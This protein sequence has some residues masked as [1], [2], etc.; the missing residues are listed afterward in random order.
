MLEEFF[1]P[2]S[3]A[4]LGAST[5]EQKLGH[6]VLKNVIQYG[7]K[8]KV[9]PINPRAESVLGLPAFRDVL[10]V[11]EP[12]DLAIM[13]VPPEA[14][15]GA[16]R[17]C[18]EKGV[19]G[20]I[21]ITAGFREIGPEG[22][23]REKELVD[24]V[25]RSGM[26]LLGPNVLGLIDTHSRLN[27]SFAARMPMEG[28]ISFL[29]QSGALCTAILDWAAKE[30]L[31]FLK[32]VS[33]GNKADLNEGDFLEALHEDPLTKVIIAYLEGIVDGRQ[34][35]EVASE[36]TKQKPVIVVKSGTTSA[37]MRAVSSHTGT[38]AGSE[39]AYDAAF[40]QS[41]VIRA[42]SIE[43]LFD[44]SMAFSYQPIPRGRNLAIVTNAGGPGILATDAAEKQGDAL[45]LA[46]FS[47]PTIEYLRRHLP[48]TANVYN[49]VDLIGD[50]RADRYAIALN[51]L[52][53]EPNVNAVLV[54][55][56]PQAVTEVDETA[57]VV[58]EAA[59]NSDKT[60]LA[61]FMGGVDVESGVRI[62]SEGRVPNYEFPE[63]A[64]EALAAMS[65]Q[66]VW[67][68]KKPDY[69]V[70]FQVDKETVRHVLAAAKEDG[71]LT[72]GDLETRQVLSAYGLPVT[73]SRVAKTPEEAA[74]YADEIGYPVV[75]KIVSPDI[76]HKS[77]VGGVRVGVY[78]PEAVKEAF[79]EIVHRVYSFMPDAEIWGIDVQEMVKPGRE[80]IIGVSNDPQFGHLIMFGLG[81]IYVEVMR[82][83]T[84]RVAPLT[85]EEARA[86]TR[87]I[88][89]YPLLM[90]VRGQPPADMKTLVDCLLRISQLVQ[91]FPQINELDINPLVLYS[92]SE[93]AVAVDSRLGI[94]A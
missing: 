34:F 90:G 10:A 52:L 66:R 53:Q 78:T 33:L 85:P 5:D 47:A 75:M 20:L 22:A 71:R 30:E 65:R 79:E 28:N 18:A 11:P 29:S 24:V 4:V 68:E 16:A 49:P 38:L 54:L 62:L 15:I 42:G 45:T 67:M 83:V 72:L 80:V 3:V 58:V 86:M 40:K 82:D 94:S 21:V 25:R 64:I 55:L 46:S 23:Q 17:Q 12:V 91:D 41:G 81:G 76:L 26:R 43:T 70:W 77:D 57:R 35:I 73:K 27:A 36:V 6:T 84:F 92:E 48:E 69:P 59:R 93:G 9:F 32:F 89:G 63:R 51:A 61:S 7:Y 37:G 74:A 13:V 60:V 39:A 8:G 14:V 87:E 31:G 56:T 88:R 2:R 44:L 1:S 19:R 50:A